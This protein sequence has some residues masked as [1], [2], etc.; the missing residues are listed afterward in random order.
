MPTEA[1]Q[2]ATRTYRERN[3]QILADKQ[4]ARRVANPDERW[5]ERKRW[6]HTLTGKRM[7]HHTFLAI[8]GEGWTPPG[9]EHEYTMIVTSDPALTLYTG[10]P[11]S[12]LNCLNFI[13]D[14]PYVKNQYITSF[15]FDYDVTMILRDFAREEPILAAQL[16]ASGNKYVW[17]KGFGLK[18]RP[19]KNLTVKRWV[20]RGKG[21]RVE[22]HDGQGFFQ[23][24]FVV[25][26]TKFNIGTPEQRAA[27]AAMKDQRSTFTAEDA[28][29]VLAYSREECRLLVSLMEQVRD[30]SQAA[31]I[32]AEPYEGPGALAQRALE[33]YYG[34]AQHRTVLDLMPPELKEWA[35]W[36]MYGGRFE[37]TAVGNIPS[38]VNEWDVKSAYP[39]E[40][41]KLPC[42][43]HGRWSRT[44]K[45]RPG[46][47]TLSHL[48]FT[49]SRP[50]EPGLAYP[51]PVRSRG[52]A[53]HYPQSG[54]GW[55]WQHEYTRDTLTVDIH[56]SYT[57]LPDGC[58]CRPF[59][60][61][62]DLYAQ[63][64]TMEA[65]S[66]GS[67]IVLKL[68]LNTL[69]GKCAQ[70]KPVPGAWLNFIYAS[71]ITSRL[72]TRMYDLYLS[73]PTRSVVMFATD[74]VFTVGGCVVETSHGLGGLEHAGT[75]RD[76]TIIQPGLYFDGP[77]SHFKTR[78][79]GKKYIIAHG[80]ELRAAAVTGKSVSLHVIQF[81]GLRMSLH[82][83][84][85][86]D[87]GNWIGREDHDGPCNDNCNLR[88][89]QT[90]TYSKRKHETVIDGITWTDPAD[91]TGESVPREGGMADYQ[92]YL[93]DIE[94]DDETYT[95]E[96]ERE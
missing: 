11:L 92:A 89:I 43:V 66:K 81:K 8:D 27:I 10:Q 15:F 88:T 65:Q 30:L 57:W 28:A 73:L 46:A 93:K 29:E 19:H 36:S 1:Q 39:Y 83:E 94:R 3:R 70:T 96:G 79:I 50:P 7:S 86:V 24:S 78:G 40:M 77:T 20:E 31:G 82:N 33:R 42:L 18:Y 25:A 21:Q 6:K 52:G 54:S 90:R 63:R 87:M 44:R 35:P 53:L 16:F 68:C 17:W 26:L 84:N 23:S 37:I 14:L 80:E 38:E 62:N 48:S 12:T 72:R 47:L 4:A 85:Y 69:Y 22:L 2:R 41:S 61:I 59:A 76:M 9:G 34:K 71:L 56:A 45:A 64:E 49:D 91:E 51:L 55:Y 13:A 95:F 74:A 67:G 58:S 5:A 60:W 75:Y 32:N